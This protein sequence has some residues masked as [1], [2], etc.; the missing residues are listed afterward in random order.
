MKLSQISNI[1]MNIDSNPFKTTCLFI[2]SR[3]AEGRRESKTEHPT[4]TDTD[5]CTFA[6]Y[7]TITDIVGVSVN[8]VKVDMRIPHF[9]PNERRLTFIGAASASGNFITEHVDFPSIGPPTSGSVIAQNNH[10]THSG[11][12]GTI[13]GFLD[14]LGDMDGVFVKF[15]TS[16]NSA[17]RLFYASRAQSGRE[18]VA[19]VD[20]PMARRLGFTKYSTS[21]LN[22][23][24]SNQSV[25][26]TPITNDTS[27]TSTSPVTTDRHAQNPLDFDVPTLYLHCNLDV[28]SEQQ[29]G[30]KNIIYK[31]CYSQREMYDPTHM[32]THNPYYTDDNHAAIPVDVLTMSRP[33]NQLRL[34][35]HYEDGTLADLNG[36]EWDMQVN[37]ISKKKA[38]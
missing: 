14:V 4:N 12:T 36:A 21:T 20:T 13:E 35:W 1:I 15:P 17:D 7:K 22:L 19:I 26:H 29:A 2:D 32:Q 33:L 27:L 23:D 6:L 24:G 18:Y 16:L 11:I 8:R 37:L 38:Y 31:T 28:N 3:N 9:K 25:R 10:H 34:S 5:R 30:S